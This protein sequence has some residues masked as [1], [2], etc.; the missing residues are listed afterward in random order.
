MLL[1]GETSV[2]AGC[3]DNVHKYD[4]GKLLQLIAEPVI[5]EV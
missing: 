2:L 3:H 4:R 1:D 5:A